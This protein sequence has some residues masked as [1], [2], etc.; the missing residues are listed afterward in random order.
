M[1]GSPVSDWAKT[2]TQADAELSRSIGTVVRWQRAKFESRLPPTHCDAW[3]SEQVPSTVPPLAIDMHDVLLAHHPQPELAKHVPQ[4]GRLS[5]PALAAST[6]ANASRAVL[7]PMTGHTR[8]KR[9]RK[10]ER[11]STLIRTILPPIRHGSP[12]DLF[13]GS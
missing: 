3:K 4:D 2:A 8:A 11:S 12:K 7:K 13:R 1:S 10:G 9:Q 6:C 5:H